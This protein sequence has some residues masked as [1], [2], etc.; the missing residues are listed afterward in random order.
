MSVGRIPRH[1]QNPSLSS[2]GENTLINHH[3]QSP[4]PHVIIGAS[5]NFKQQC[6]FDAG[7]TSN[8]HWSQPQDAY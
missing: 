6:W 1:A 5:L 2:L 7:P 3:A 4:H 8:Q